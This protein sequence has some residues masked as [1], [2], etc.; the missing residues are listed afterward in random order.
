MYEC[1]PHSLGES[2]IGNELW[3]SNPNRIFHH[4]S[5]YELGGEYVR[6]SSLKWCSHLVLMRT[7]SVLGKIVHIYLRGTQN[8]TRTSFLDWSL[9]F[10]WLHQWLN[11]NK[12]VILDWELSLHRSWEKRKKI[13][14]MALE[15]QHCD[16]IF[17]TSAINALWKLPANVGKAPVCGITW[18]GLGFSAM[19]H[20]FPHLV[21][22][23]RGRSVSEAF[24]YKNQACWVKWWQIY[25]RHLSR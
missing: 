15:M 23:A 18:H 7:Q 12:R 21:E 22:L 20:H 17:R 6:N 14:D 19:K 8:I 1:D 11:Q 5:A 25:A 3:I 13:V 16:A 10:P 2:W 9:A 4:H 24:C